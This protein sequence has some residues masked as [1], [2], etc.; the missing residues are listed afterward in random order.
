[1]VALVGALPC[2]EHGC[3]I[4][5]PPGCP[6]QAFEWVGGVLGCAVAQNPFEMGARVLP[7]CLVER[8]PALVAVVRGC[9]RHGPIV[10]GPDRESTPC[11]RRGFQPDPP[12]AVSAARRAPGGFTPSG[13]RRHGSGQGQDSLENVRRAM[14]H[15]VPG[16]PLLST[17]TPSRGVTKS[18]GDH[19]FSASLR[20][21]R[22]RR[23]SEPQDLRLD[24]VSCGFRRAHG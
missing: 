20:P 8:S 1:M 5:E 4:V 24:W 19:I 3:L 9:R 12:P 6:A 21:V 15:N 11:G 13:P 17:P 2:V 18:I 16:R 14:V 23:G 22:L 10:G 7:A